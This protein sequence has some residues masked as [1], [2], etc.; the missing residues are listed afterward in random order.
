MALPWR[1]VIDASNQPTA[2]QNYEHGATPVGGFLGPAAQLTNGRKYLLLAEQVDGDGNPSGAWEVSTTTWNDAAPDNFSGRVLEDSS[3]GSLIDWS[4]AGVNVV[5]RL[6]VLGE[7]GAQHGPRRILS[8]NF[9][10]DAS[11]DFA[12]RAGCAYLVKF[13]NIDYSAD[14]NTLCA[15]VSTDGSTFDA[16]ANDYTWGTY[17]ISGGASGSG[18]GDSLDSEMEFGQNAWAG[19]DVGEHTNGFLWFDDPADAAGYT[20]AYGQLALTSYTGTVALKAVYAT[21]LA[22]QADVAVR[23]FPLT[24]NFATGRLAVWEFPL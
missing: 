2:A 19:N 18:A 14:Q 3:S 10:N 13:A 6:T 7:A 21:R 8:I 15:R 24:G 23:L 11:V 1:V 4:A 12:C 9:A 17:I 5:P 22:A 16:G 20:R